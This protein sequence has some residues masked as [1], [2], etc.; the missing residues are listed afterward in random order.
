MLNCV[1]CKCG[2]LRLPK[3]VIDAELKKLEHS[4]DIE[5]RLTKIETICKV[6][7]EC[8]GKIKAA[9]NSDVMTDSDQQN[10]CHSLQYK[11]FKRP[12]TPP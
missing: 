3:T 4:N 12:Y 6:V 7:T 5:K 8:G 1:C 10:H 11:Y 9:S 2:H